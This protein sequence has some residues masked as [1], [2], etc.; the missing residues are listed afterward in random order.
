[1]SLELFNAIGSHR[2]HAVETYV[3]ESLLHLHHLFVANAATRWRLK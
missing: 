2:G 3:I 1:V